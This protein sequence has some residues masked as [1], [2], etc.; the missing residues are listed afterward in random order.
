[1]RLRRFVG[2]LILGISALITAITSVT[3][4]AISLTQQV[5][6]AQYVDTMSKNVSLTLTTQE[7]IDKKLEMRADALEEAIM[8]IG[9]DL[10][11]LKLKMAL[12][13]HADYRWICVTSLK[14]N[15]T[16]YEWEKIKNHI[17]GVWNSSDIGL[18]LGKLH[19]Q[20]QTLEH[21][22]LDFTAA[23]AANDFF[24]TFSNFISGKNILS[25]ILGYIAAGAL[26]LLLIIVLPCIV[27]I[28]RQNIQKLAT[29]L[30][31]AV[32][33]NKKGGD[34]GSRHIAY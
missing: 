5:H 8:H 15:E 3:V 6:T 17:S 25:N 33:R 34:A 30:H 23:G 11:A 28:L 32:L 29:E 24:H 21:S 18:D 2:L 26:I 14:V 13:C 19:N 16:D 31:L 9:T 20:I 22:Q 4:A 12:S 27:R 7:A 1:M 10:Q